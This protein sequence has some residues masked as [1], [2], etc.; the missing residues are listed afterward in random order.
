MTIM[1]VASNPEAVSR[2]VLSEAS[3]TLCKMLWGYIGL[4]LMYA[5]TSEFHI[6]SHSMRPLMPISLGAGI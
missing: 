3:M 1:T 6:R 5:P 4:M 2:R